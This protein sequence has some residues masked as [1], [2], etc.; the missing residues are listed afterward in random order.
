MVKSMVRHGAARWRLL[1]GL[2]FALGL[3]QVAACSS[4]AS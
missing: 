3:T 4:T 2:A 1:G